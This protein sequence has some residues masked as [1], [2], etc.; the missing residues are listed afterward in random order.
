MAI[1][2]IE[3]RVADFDEWKAVFDKDPMGRPAHG[4]TGHWIYRDPDDPK[5]HMVSLRFASADKA[6]AFR[7]AM[8]PVWEVSGAGQAWV[9]DE[10]DV[11]TY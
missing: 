6:K 1:L 8:Q 11:R 7:T 2:L 4:V 9:L 5:H 3:Y 10:A